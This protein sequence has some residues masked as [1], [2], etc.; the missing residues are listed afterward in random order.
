MHELFHILSSKWKNLNEEAEAQINLRF[1]IYTWLSHPHC[2][3][4]TFN[5]LPISNAAITQN[6]T[7]QKYYD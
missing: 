4:T 7:T 6:N 2:S 3:I 5:S 1:V